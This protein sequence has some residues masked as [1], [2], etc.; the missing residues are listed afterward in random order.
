MKSD[1]F[2]VTLTVVDVFG[3][4]TE[5]EYQTDL[6]KAATKKVAKN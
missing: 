3:N 1:A 2:K 5:S 4:K 6:Y